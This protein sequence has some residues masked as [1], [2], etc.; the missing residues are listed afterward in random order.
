MDEDI[1]CF[2]MEKTIQY[3]TTLKAADDFV[4][5]YIHNRVVSFLISGK[6]ETCVCPAVH[7]RVW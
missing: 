5:S 7:I 3:D 1:N 6:M 4:E 2:Q